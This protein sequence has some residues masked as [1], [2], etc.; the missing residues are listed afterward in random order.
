MNRK[1]FRIDDV[2]IHADYA[3]MSK[4]PVGRK[5]VLIA[6]TEGAQH[7]Q[8]FQA[9]LQSLHQVLPKEPVLAV[10]DLFD[11]SD[12]AALG[13]IIRDWTRHVNGEAFIP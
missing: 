2:T 3:D 11:K 6:E 10:I 8:I 4:H 9:D 7:I 5:P 12:R 13:R 1:F